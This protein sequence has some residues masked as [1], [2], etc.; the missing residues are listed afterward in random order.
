MQR[1]HFYSLLLGTLILSGAGVLGLQSCGGKDRKIINENPLVSQNALA[2]ETPSEVIAT[3]VSSKNRG[4]VNLNYKSSWFGNSGTN[5]ETAVQSWIDTIQV[6]ADGS[7]YAYVGWDEAHG[8][9][10]RSIYKN[11]KRVGQYSD[12]IKLDPHRA[13]VGGKAWKIKNAKFLGGN[14]IEREDGKCKITDAGTP[15][16]IA[17]TNDGKLMVADNGRRQYIRIYDVNNCRPKLVKTFGEEGGVFS[18]GKPPGVVEPLRFYGLNGVGMDAKGNICVGGQIVGGGGWIR[19]LSPQG[20]MLWQVYSAGWL[21]NAAADYSTDGKVF[22]SSSAAYKMDY[23]RTKPGTE[24]GNFPH[25]FTINIFKYP[26][27][28]RATVFHFDKDKPV[29]QQPQDA[30]ANKG[31]HYDP[32]PNGI[33]SVRKCGKV[34]YLYGTWQNGGGIGIFKADA[35]GIFSPTTIP[36]DVDTDAWAVHVD[37]NCNLWVGKG[38]PKDGVL[39]YKFRG[40][41]KQG[42]MQFEKVRKF[43][44]PFADLGMIERIYYDTKT[45]SLYLTGFTDARPVQFG[46]GQVGSTMYRWDGWLKGKRKLHPAYPAIFPHQGYGEGSSAGTA[47]GSKTK[48]DSD[49]S[50]TYKSI[51]WA[52]KYAFASFFS[53]D[54]PH[55]EKGVT[56]IYDLDTAKKIGSFKPGAALN[57]KGE[58]GWVDI[59]NGNSAYLRANGEYVVSVEENLFNKYFLYRW[60]PSGNCQ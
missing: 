42:N 39:F 12:K 47:D 55:G 9:R 56:D 50:Q 27:D 34:K 44:A 14:V 10:E 8:G 59:I 13:V 4:K 31:A 37:D 24:A 45:D 57:Q 15:N 36:K 35:S 22:Y 58:V 46:W 16:A 33:M 25:Q 28:I 30:P 49:N 20:K 17:P 41:D 40:N 32:K 43:S 7:V 5:R 3:E 26:Q 23:S 18:R 54:R 60:C 52:G 2:S 48:F 53:R 51:A 29:F 11:G 19:C 21:S 1:Y 38:N 6:Q